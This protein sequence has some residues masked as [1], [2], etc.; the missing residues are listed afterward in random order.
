MN[1]SP[2]LWARLWKKRVIA[3]VHSGCMPEFIQRW[4][5]FA[6]HV[7]SLTDLVLVPHEFLQKRLTSL[8]VRIDDTIP[9]FIDVE[10]YRY[11][12]RSV[13]LPRFL[14]LRGMYAYYNPEMAIRAF[15]LVQR[16]YPDASLTM[17]GEGA[18]ESVTCQNLVRHLGVRNVSFV[19]L[20][21]KEEIPKL[22]DQH[23]IHL[24]TSK[25]ENMPVTILMWACG[26]PIVG[27]NVGGMP[28][29]VRD[30]I[31][32]ILVRSED[33]EAMAHVCLDLLSNSEL[34][35]RLSRNGRARAEAFTWQSIKP[36]WEKALL[37]SVSSDGMRSNQNGSQCTLDNGGAR[38]RK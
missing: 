35:R 8:G 22:A 38:R 3:L 15:S 1:R 32:A 29:L 30:G 18:K 21:S 34:C 17:A 2:L 13:I 10:R 19:G 6:T 33:H 27:T 9:N 14:Y 12:E 36:L 5:R 20:V 31:D 16:K 7:L 4:R 23:D 25:V 26:L 37:L 11:R 24:H 28:Y